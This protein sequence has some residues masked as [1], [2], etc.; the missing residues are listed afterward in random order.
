MNL[1]YRNICTSI[2]KH[3]DKDIHC[4]IVC[5]STRLETIYLSIIR[6]MAKLIL[7][8]PVNDIYWYT[9]PAERLRQ[10][11]VPFV[12]L[13]LGQQNKVKSIDSGAI[14]QLYHLWSVWLWKNC[15]TFLPQFPH[16]KNGGDNHSTY[17]RWLWWEINW[18]KW[19]AWHVS[20]LYVFRRCRAWNLN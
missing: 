18:L 8:Y 9:A 11:K 5:E 1:T 10:E 15:L 13:S 20:M 17:F 6:G 14:D 19:Q 12:V 3:P 7:I 4:S 2:P 16:L